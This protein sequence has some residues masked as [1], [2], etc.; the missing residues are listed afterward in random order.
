[1]ITYFAS[2]NKINLK[3][4]LNATWKDVKDDAT[5]I[6]VMRIEFIE[7]VEVSSMEKKSFFFWLKSLQSFVQ[8]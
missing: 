7:T 1:M 6:L 5:V 2:D 8:G 3:F 4:E